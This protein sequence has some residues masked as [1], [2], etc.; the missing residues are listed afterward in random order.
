[1]TDPSNAAQERAWDGTEGELWAVHADLLEQV[2]VRYD[3]ALLEQ[4]GVD[5]PETALV[6]VPRALLRRIRDRDRVLDVR[7][8]G[9]P[10]GSDERI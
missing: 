3:G 5:G 6:A 4:I 1:M 7:V 8:H 10:L 2:F 9:A